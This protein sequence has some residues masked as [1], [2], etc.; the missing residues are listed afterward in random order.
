M[1]N[2]RSHRLSKRVCLVLLG[3][4]V[5]FLLFLTGCASTSYRSSGS[6]QTET[7]DVEYLSAYGVWADYPPYGVVW[8]PD[9]VPGWEPFYYGHWIWTGDGWAWTSYEPYGWLVY[10][11]GYWG[12]EPGFGWFWVPGNTWY[13]ACV[14]W[15]T[16]GDYVA[17]AP[18]PPPSILWPDPWDPYDVNIWIVVDIDNFTNENIGRHRVVRSVYRERGQNKTVVRRAPDVKQVERVSERTVPTIRIREQETTIR[19]RAGSKQP[20]TVQRREP[21]SERKVLP[22]TEKRKVDSKQPAT[23]Q[24][25]EPVLKRV[26]LP[27][28]EK[29]KVEKH[30]AKVEREVLTS[31]KK[32]PAQ[33]AKSP[34]RK[35]DTKDR[36]TDTKRKRK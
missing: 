30:A 36:N 15:Y 31:R 13:P 35:T 33:P 28:A 10:H 18:L 3:L 14:Q 8:L 25:K 26:V 9:V 4:M 2:E 6:V 1:C 7:D 27:S 17:W 29:R 11:Y 23:V 16:F 5:S 22:E 12:Y 32:P 20:A 19:P 24:R 21:V 34:D